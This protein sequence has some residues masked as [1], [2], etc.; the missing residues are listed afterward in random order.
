MKG[1]KENEG[2]PKSGTALRSAQG[3]L[4]LFFANPSK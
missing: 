1:E 4:V 2:M 3:V